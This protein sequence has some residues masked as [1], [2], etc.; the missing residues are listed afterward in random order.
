MSEVYGRMTEHYDHNCIRQ[1]RD[2]EP[3]EKL[4]GSAE[5]CFR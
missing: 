4:K 3:A 1:R 5:A 2:D